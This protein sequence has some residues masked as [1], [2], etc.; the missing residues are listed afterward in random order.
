MEFGWRGFTSKIYIIWVKW[1]AELLLVSLF[2]AMKILLKHI[3]T[4]LRGQ[5]IKLRYC[6]N[7][8]GPD[9]LNI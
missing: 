4:D 9:K 5:K 1:I 2:A 3:A 7:H 6:G 8:F